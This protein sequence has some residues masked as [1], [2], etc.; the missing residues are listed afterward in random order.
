MSAV[1]IKSKKTRSAAI[2]SK[3]R[4]TAAAEHI[5]DSSTDNEKT[6]SQETAAASQMDDALVTFIVRRIAT[7]RAAIRAN[8]PVTVDSKKGAPAV[9]EVAIPTSYLSDDL[10]VPATVE[11]NKKS[12][13]AVN[14]VT[15]PPR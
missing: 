7:K 5:D 12:T 8:V 14:E 4:S 9:N 6:N 15:A 3:T 10:N 2:A 11:S 1:I 13:L